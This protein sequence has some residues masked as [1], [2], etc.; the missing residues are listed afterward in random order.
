LHQLADAAASE[1]R[2]SDAEKKQDES[3]IPMHDGK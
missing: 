2:H 1:H 3:K